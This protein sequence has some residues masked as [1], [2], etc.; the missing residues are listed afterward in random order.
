MGR[1]V[2][3]QARRYGSLIDDLQASFARERNEYPKT[4]EKAIDLLDNRK[5]DSRFKAN[6]E[7]SEK[8]RSKSKSKSTESNS[9]SSGTT[10]VQNKN[11]NS[12]FKC[13]CCGSPDHSPSSCPMKSK[14]DRSAWFIDTGKKPTAKP[15]HAQTES[16][17][18]TSVESSSKAKS[19]SRSA[20]TKKKVGVIS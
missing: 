14:I 5:F 2:F 19:N 1:Y 15:A 4:L 3:Y 17:D 7:T 18:E 9:K 20:T 12:N 10:L 6:A 11:S 16:K 8:D 13:H